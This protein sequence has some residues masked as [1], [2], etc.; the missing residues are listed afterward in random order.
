MKKD[1]K[2]KINYMGKLYEGVVYS[3][4]NGGSTINVKFKLNDKYVV[5]AFPKCSVMLNI[6]NESLKYDESRIV[7]LNVP[8][9]DLKVGTKLIEIGN[10]F[11]SK[12]VITLNGEFYSIPLRHFE[13][14]NSASESEENDIINESMVNN[15]IE[16][17]CS[18]NGQLGFF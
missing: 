1:D 8:F 10:I 9:R 7:T 6:E 12:T 18:C 15:S 4:Y 16:Y 13:C 2:V 3:V 17:T 5:T 11:S 14:D